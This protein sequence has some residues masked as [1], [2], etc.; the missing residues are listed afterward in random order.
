MGR[1]V[2]SAVL[3]AALTI[4]A[5]CGGTEGDRGPA[6]ELGPQGDPGQKGDPGPPGEPGPQ[7]D[8]GPKGDPGAQGVVKVLGFESDAPKT[9]LT[10][11]TGISEIPP[12]CT[13]GS[14]VAGD[15]EWA[16]I[17]MDTSVT[18]N[19][20]TGGLLYLTAMVDMGTGFVD[21]STP[22]TPSVDG[23]GD[24]AASVSVTKHYALTS[25]TTYTFGAKI[26]ST[27]GAG[28]LTFGSWFCHGTVTIVKE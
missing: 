14:H 24:G 22:P 25:G 11:S 18:V 7:G 28:S 3:L 13:T 26:K 20:G 27:G 10:L 5:G 4:F 23:Y 6:G 2:F 19:S 15:N 12:P 17:D 8:A 21:T 9:P 16:L 1:C